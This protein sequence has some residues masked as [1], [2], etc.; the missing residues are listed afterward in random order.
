VPDEPLPGMDLSVAVPGD[1]SAGSGADL[2]GVHDLASP[3]DLTSLDLSGPC[4]KV[5]MAGDM[6]S[7]SCSWT[8]TCHGHTYV[9]SCYGY[10]C[11]E[12]ITDGV[13]GSQAYCNSGGTCSANSNGG[14]PWSAFCHF[15]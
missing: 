7:A 1:M 3:P 14:Y 2:A 10:S 15:P 11:C 4:T 6:G 9:E 5:Y 13:K 12:C 8:A